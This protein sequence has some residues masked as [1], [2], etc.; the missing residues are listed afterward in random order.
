MDESVAYNHDDANSYYSA[1]KYLAE[2]EA[3]RGREEGLKVAIIN[4]CIILGFGNWN[5]GSA[6]FF[7]NARKGF[8]FYTSGA[9]AFVDVRDVA[10][11]AY[12]LVD[13]QKFD[14]KYLCTGWNKTFYEVFEKLANEFGAKPPRIQVS[15]WMSEV[16]WRISGVLQFFTGN[17]LITKESARSGLKTVRYDN[18]KIRDELDFNF[19]DFE[20]SISYHVATYQEAQKNPA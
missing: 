19:T 13:Q 16:A 5:K 4:P 3:F 11:C 8:P 15:K 1:T 12:R 20:E 7:K 17:G 9:N 10:E 18:S 6:G 14:G 2:L